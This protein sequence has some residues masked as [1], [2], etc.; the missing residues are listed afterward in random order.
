MACD[1]D[2][3][4]DIEKEDYDVFYISENIND[5]DSF[6]S[7]LSAKQ[8]KSSILHMRSFDTI[9]AFDNSSN[10]IVVVDGS[11]LK[12]DIAFVYS[13][14]K[15]KFKHFKVLVY[16]MDDIKFGFKHLVPISKNKII[17]SFLE[18]LNQIKKESVEHSGDQLVKFFMI[19]VV[20][21]AIV[22][23]VLADMRPS[24]AAAFMGGIVVLGF[25]KRIFKMIFFY[26]GMKKAQA[27]C[28][29]L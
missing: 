11:S 21:I 25:S 1:T 6:R 28:E 12:E 22:T 17:S 2:I 18:Q 5:K 16:N 20:L 26:L 8:F 15:S 4:K 3:L 9:D 7:V 19:A 24:Y 13:K 10:A 14:L 27:Y 23:I 29:C